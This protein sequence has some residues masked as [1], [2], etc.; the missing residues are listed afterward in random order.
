MIIAEML[1]PMHPSLAQMAGFCAAGF[2]LVM[3]VLAFQSVLTSLIG[4]I[5]TSVENRKK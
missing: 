5:F 4:R 1:I 3:F 2:L